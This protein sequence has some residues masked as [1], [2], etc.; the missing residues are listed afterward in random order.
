MGWACDLLF[1][2]YDMTYHSGEP[3]E[4]LVLLE[5]KCCPQN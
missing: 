3:G 5:M 2:Q 1:L 4:E